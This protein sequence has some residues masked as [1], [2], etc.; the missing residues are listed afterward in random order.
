MCS[1]PFLTTGS[2]RDQSITK[3]KMSLIA[4]VGIA[5]TV[6]FVFSA[7]ASPP[8]PHKPPT[9][10]RWPR[11]RRRRKREEELAV[12]SI[13]GSRRQFAH[14]TTS[15]VI[16]VNEFDVRNAQYLFGFLYA[17]DY[18]LAVWSAA[19][20]DELKTLM[21]ASL[22]PL[23][24]SS[25]PP[26]L[27]LLLLISH[28]RYPED[29]ETALAQS[30]KESP[31]HPGPLRSVNSTNHLSP[32]QHT[33]STPSPNRFFPRMSVPNSNPPH[34]KIACRQAKRDAEERLVRF[35]QPI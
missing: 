25:S 9:A 5:R 2:P 22:Q 21:E 31:T 8:P 7:A 13:A 33:D 6:A 19:I 26:P 18:R 32:R 30:P 14:E 24:F 4:Q 3:R 34:S 11:V 12:R 20:I 15:K 17:A 16:T 10:P 1:R 23:V 27:L 29:Q 28:P 35:L